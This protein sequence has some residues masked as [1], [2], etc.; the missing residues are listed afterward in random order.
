MNFTVV[1]LPLAQNELATMWVKAADRTA[2][3]EA[4]Y[5]IDRRLHVDPLDEGESR[6]GLERITFDSPLRVFFRVF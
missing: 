6:E 2:V 4:S 5:R 3:T 1:W